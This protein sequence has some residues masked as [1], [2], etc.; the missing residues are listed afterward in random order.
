MPDSQVPQPC[1]SPDGIRV[2]IEVN[3]DLG[4][5]VEEKINREDE[6]REMHIG[7][8][9]P[10]PVT[11]PESGHGA[12][13]AV[14]PVEGGDR[15]D[16]SSLP[17]GFIEVSLDD[18]GKAGGPNFVGSEM[19]E[20]I[21][22]AGTEGLVPLCVAIHWIMT[23]GGTNQTPFDDREAWDGACRKLFAF[24]VSGEIG[25]IGTPW[26]GSL[27][28]QI[29]GYA[30]ATIKILSPVNGSISDFCLN[31]PSFIDCSTYFDGKFWEDFNDKLFLP[32]QPRASWTQLQV[33]KSDILGR[34]PR[35]VPKV[36]AQQLCLEWLKD[37]ILKSP[38]S[39]PRSRQTFFEEAKMTCAGLGRRQFNRAWDIAVSEPHALAWKKPG[40]IPRSDQDTN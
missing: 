27:S 37:E 18:E 17:T 28:G 40:P 14:S 26:D 33:K 22:R 6:A 29:P 25:L 11:E 1:H 32:G 24:I 4:G 20:P 35:P 9:E 8:A 7:L 2:S 34:W 39:R 5:A 21:M 15:R 16:E 19:L 10:R 31:E 23:S 13:E 36:P 3:S 12:G 38:D 30:L